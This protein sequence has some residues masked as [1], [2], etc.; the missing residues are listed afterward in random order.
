[1]NGL[2]FKNI[3]HLES[4]LGGIL[5]K[6]HGIDLIG[7]VELLLLLAFEFLTKFLVFLQE[8]HVVVISKII[9]IGFLRGHRFGG[10][11]D[12]IRC[13]DIRMGYVVFKSARALIGIQELLELVEI[14]E[15][16]IRIEEEVTHGNKQAGKGGEIHRTGSTLAADHIQHQR[17]EKRWEQIF[18]HGFLDEVP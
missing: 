7:H 2:V 12:F 17:S 5:G 13:G 3:E 14:D 1:V 11:F 9:L 15:E 8:N 4:D 6:R 18:L 16:T 10:L